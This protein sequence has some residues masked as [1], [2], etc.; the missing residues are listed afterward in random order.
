MARMFIVAWEGSPPLDKAEWTAILREVLAGEL[1]SYRVLFRNTSRGW[2]FELEW[3]D[4]GRSRDADVVA[5]SPDSVVYNIYVNLAG[6]G[7]P[8]DPSWRPW[9]GTPAPARPAAAAAPK[10][11]SASPAAPPNRPAGGRRKKRGR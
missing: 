9:E 1:G 5:N 4:D 11:A 8:L 2:R 10:A 6:N 7:K 3:R